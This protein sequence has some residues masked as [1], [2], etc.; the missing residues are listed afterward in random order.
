VI[1]IEFWNDALPCGLK[2][3]V[4]IQEA[5]HCDHSLCNSYQ[6]S[7][8]KSDDHLVR[9]FTKL[10]L[11]GSVR[12]AVLW[13]TERAGRGLLSPDKSVVRALQSKHPEPS[14]PPCDAIPSC[15]QLPYLEN[16]EITAAHVQGGAGPRGCNSAHWR[17]VLLQHGSS[18]V[19]L[20]EAV[21]ALYQ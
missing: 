1:F 13:I 14:I 11:Q 19:H 18:S 6:S 9:V 20:R 12:S 21:A 15:E 10:M 8:D 17:D 3:N 4:L 16:L 5:Q 2:V 7:V